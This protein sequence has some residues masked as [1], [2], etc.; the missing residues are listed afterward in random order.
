[1]G[2]RFDLLAVPCLLVLVALNQIRLA[3]TSWL[4]P[5]KGGGFGM[6]SSTDDPGQRFIGTEAGDSSDRPIAIK[7]SFP[8]GILSTS[9]A[10]RL[11]CI[12]DQGLLQLVADQMLRLPFVPTGI[13]RESLIEKV[14]SGNP[15]SRLPVPA[16]GGEPP[17]Y[18][19]LTNRDPRVDPGR[20]TVLRRLTLQMWRL[21]F[22]PGTWRVT[23]PR[24]PISATSEVSPR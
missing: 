2:R 18:R 15:Q 12:P 9:S 16:E 10:R 21:V 13:R 19:V 1:M 20:L 24:L 7:M 6:F 17:V 3:H 4:S 22:D 11:S 5:W 14:R 23:V 8:G